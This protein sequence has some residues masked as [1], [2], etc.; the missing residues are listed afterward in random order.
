LYQRNG[1]GSSFQYIHNNLRRGKNKRCTP[2][3]E[4]E[5]AVHN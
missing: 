1:N 2:I 5:D 4:D 3:E